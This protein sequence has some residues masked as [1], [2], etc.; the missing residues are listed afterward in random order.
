MKVKAVFLVSCFFGFGIL[1]AEQTK[2]IYN[3]FTGRSDFITALTTS[4]IQAGSNVVVTT[5]SSGVIISASTGSSL[6]DIEGVTAGSG[7]SGGGT[8]GTVTLSLN[9]GATHY[10]HNQNTLQDNA[11]SYVRNSYIQKSVVIGTGTFVSDTSTGAV[12]VHVTFANNT[13][14]YGVDH[15]TF[16]EVD[17]VSATGAAYMDFYDFTPGDPVYHDKVAS[18]GYDGTGAR[19]KFRDSADN[20]VAYI[21][22][23]ESSGTIFSEGV[24]FNRLAPPQPNAVRSSQSIQRNS[25]FH[26]VH[27]ET[28]PVV[29][30]MPSLSQIDG[31]QITKHQYIFCKSDASSNT[32]TFTGGDGNDTVD[33]NATLNYPNQCV[34]LISSIT[35]GTSVGK[36]FVAMKS[37][38]N[39][40]T[41]GVINVSTNPVDWTL[42]KN[43]PAGFAD[44]VDGTGGGGG[45]TIVVQE[46]GST[47]IE[48]STLTFNSDQFDVSDLTGKG[49]VVINTMTA[50][51]IMALSTGTNSAGQLVRLDS[52]ADVPDANLSA[53][54]SLL[55]SQIDISGETNLTASN[56]ITLTDDA[57]SVNWSSAISR[58]DVAAAY[59]PLD[60]TLTDLA[61]AP[62]G[63]DNSISVGAIAAGTL[64]TDVMA[65]SFPATGVIAGNYGS[66]TQITTFTVN[67][68][69]FVTGVSTISFASGDNISVNG[70]ATTNADFDDDEPAAVSNT[71]NVI[72]QTD[73]TNISAHVPYNSATIEI[74]G[75][76]ISAIAGS[77]DMILASTQSI[78]GAKKFNSYT[79]FIGTVTFASTA[80]FSGAVVGSNGAGT[81]GQVLTSS[82]P[83]NPPYWASS[84]GGATTRNAYFSASAGLCQLTSGCQDPDQ[85]ETAAT[86]TSYIAATFSAGTTHY[87]QTNFTLPDDYEDGTTFTAIIEWTSTATVTNTTWG[88]DMKA[89]SNDDSLDGVWGTGVSVSDA[90][91]AVGD[92]MRT[93]ESSPITAAGSP[94]SGDRLF[95]RVYRGDVVGDARFAGIQIKYS[96]D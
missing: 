33:S 40:S 86:S 51:G 36:W 84:S 62:L 1:R 57:L 4:S 31:A 35:G 81:S 20:V 27:A 47:V 7:L 95:I 43:V 13:E 89:V 73:G 79:N 58:S 48:T 25:Y 85:Y 66:S 2:S 16:M 38:A 65:S 29:I 28:V 15:N 3:P 41:P 94:V 88:I 21:D 9:P 45:T 76:G 26:R 14:G 22:V 70:S 80:A 83:G 93:A 10:I 53:S 75:G 90:T 30:T 17:K 63:E 67:A 12:P 52:N 8:T 32:V 54:V 64:P 71:L 78:S 91:T 5:T 18:W 92:L 87:W 49:S 39:L 46:G 6:G 11:S 69:G 44:G 72:W 37:E 24:Q 60:A 23:D 50:G 77:G 55:G 82:G 96:L 61:A 59:Q 74:I 56:G 68:Q 34:I 19:F 42:L